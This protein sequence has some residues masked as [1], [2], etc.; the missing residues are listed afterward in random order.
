VTIFSNPVVG[1]FASAGVSTSGARPVSSFGALSSADADQVHIRYNSGGF[2]EIQMPGA[3]WDRLIFGKGTIPADPAFANVFQPESLPQSQAELVTAIARTKGYQYSEIAGWFD[4]NKFGSVAFGEA[5]PASGVPTSGSATYQGI[6]QGTSDVIWTDSFDGPHNVPV[7]GTVNL[8]FD[9]AQGT[10]GGAMTVRLDD[11][12]QILPIGT[13]AFKDTV[14][15][16]GSTSYS[17]KFN[18]TASGSNFFLGQFTGPHAE[19]TIGAW[20]LPFTIVDTLFNKF[21]PHQAFGAWIAK[22]P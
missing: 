19:E 17:G 21:T 15:S 3:D 8:S 9:F 13:F 2:Y 5:T 1:E 10:L 16:A 6:V 22:K 4:G 18:T 14:F 12:G 11:S 20:A 7:D